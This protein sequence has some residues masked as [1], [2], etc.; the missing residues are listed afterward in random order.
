[1]K[2]HEEILVMEVLARMVLTTVDDE[3]DRLIKAARSL[4]RSTVIAAH[5]EKEG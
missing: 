4:L 5:D 2:R 1:M 3:P